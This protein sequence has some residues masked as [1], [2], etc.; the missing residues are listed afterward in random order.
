MTSD[1]KDG[2]IEEDSAKVD[3]PGYSV[4]VETNASDSE[5]T[6]E[7]RYFNNTIDELKSMAY[8]AAMSGNIKLAYK[9]ERALD[10]IIEVQ[11]ENK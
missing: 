11:N 5:M 2:E 1:N 7:D 9:I 10:E 6:E 8:E 4:T 3:G